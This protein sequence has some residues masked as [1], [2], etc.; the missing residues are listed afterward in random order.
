MQK[1]ILD[2]LERADAECDQLRSYVNRF[3]EADKRAAIL[4]ERLHTN[5]AIEVLFGSGVGLGG[6][7]M[8]LAPLFWNEQPKG[9][10]ALSLGLLLILAAVTARVVKR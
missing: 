6:A 9:V 2:D 5:N 3:H 4:E 10:L 8:G 1:L 7:V